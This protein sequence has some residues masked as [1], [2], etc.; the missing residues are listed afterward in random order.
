MSEQ[1]Q[2][3]HPSNGL[4]G[5]KENIKAFPMASRQ[6]P[7]T[8]HVAAH[9]AKPRANSMRI[10][11]LLAYRSNVDM[12]SEEIGHALGLIGKPGASYWQR[13]S[14]LNK[15]GMIEPTGILRAGLSGSEQ[16]VFSITTAGRELL[17]EMG[18]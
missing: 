6:H 11:I 8:S 18:L 5:Y 12:T 2:M 16:R 14:E 15:L 1:M 17:K 9:K 4:G 13:V 3:F 10:Q 7:T